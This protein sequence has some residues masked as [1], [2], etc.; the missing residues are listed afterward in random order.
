MP[1]TKT[2]YDYRESRRKPRPSGRGGCQVHVSDDASPVGERSTQI[3]VTGHM[4]AG[5]ELPLQVRQEIEHPYAHEQ[6]QS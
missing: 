1:R 3:I 2:L 4:C 5:G 6:S